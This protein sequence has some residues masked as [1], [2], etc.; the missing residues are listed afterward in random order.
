MSAE[1]RRPGRARPRGRSAFWPTFWMAV[2][3]FLAKASHWSLP[4]PTAKRL[5]E[6]ATDLAV[7]VHA[8]VLFC[9]S[10]ACWGSWPFAW[11]R[12]R[13]RLSFLVY[14]PNSSSAWAACSTRW[15]ASRS[16]PSC[17]RP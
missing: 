5:R 9:V 4:E 13:P 2:V 7:S 3:M 17:A 12:N 6:Y 16:S 14:P 1:A 10:W 11:S 8:D 15:P